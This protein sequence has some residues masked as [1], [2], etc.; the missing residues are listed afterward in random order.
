MKT[1]QKYF[2]LALGISLLLGSQTFAQGN[3][4]VTKPKPQP[5]QQEEEV[6]DS[7]KVTPGKTVSVLQSATGWV[8]S[9]TG[10]WISSPNRI[11][12]EDPDYNNE[13][14][15]KNRIGTEN[16]NQIRVME[17]KVD[18]K[19]YYA[20]I[21]QYLKGYY[22]DPEVKENW[23]YFTGADYYLIEKKDWK[24]VYNDSLKFGTPYTVSLRS[25]YSGTVPYKTVDQ[26]GPRIGKDINV[27]IRTRHLY[28][29]TVHTYFQLAVKP[30]K[31]KRGKFI[32]FNLALGYAPSG[33]EP[34]EADYEQFASQY[35]ELPIDRFKAFARPAAK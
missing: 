9:T 13:F 28:D 34:E 7:L 17:M 8:K 10:K 26:I 23:K 18:D 16:F 35:Y 5:Q 15:E 4:P 11:P 3:K 19:M 1:V 12:F 22:P 6:K 31:D 21:V 29:T 24:K 20:V 32:R 33:E 27:N 30:V 14:Y 2:G 25:Y